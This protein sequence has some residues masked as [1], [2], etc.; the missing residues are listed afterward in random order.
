MPG[1]LFSLELAS[2][3][4]TW[5][6]IHGDYSTWSTNMNRWALSNSCETF[7]NE[8]QLY[9]WRHPHQPT[10][11]VEISVYFSN[12]LLV[13]FHYEALSVIPWALDWNDGNQKELVSYNTNNHSITTVTSV[14]RDNP[15][16]LRP[17]PNHLLCCSLSK[18]K[19]EN[20]TLGQK[21]HDRHLEHDETNLDFTLSSLFLLDSVR[22]YA[23]LADFVRIWI[24]ITTNLEL[25][26]MIR[27]RLIISSLIFLRAK[28]IT[29]CIN[30]T[31]KSTIM[32]KV[33]SDTSWGCLS[34]VLCWSIWNQRSLS[35]LVGD[36]A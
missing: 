28:K 33:S 22:P 23:E 12:L 21:R 27:S 7:P 36:G 26:Q 16:Y 34:L 30:I 6:G 32:V 10:A 3:C 5:S 29:Y 24:Y 13:H 8:S 11:L 18:N 15:E 4:T 9:T 31:N 25:V 19:E 2:Y 14:R 17:S 1:S 35:K 20:E